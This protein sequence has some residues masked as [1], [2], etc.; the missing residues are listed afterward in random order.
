[1]R[2]Y[3]LLTAAWQVVA[4]APEGAGGGGGGAEGA[5]AAAGAAAAAAAGAAAGAGDGGGSLLS[6][7]AAAAAGDAGKA[8]AGDGKPAGEEGKPGEEA[9]PGEEKTEEYQIQP[10]ALDL[11][12][13]FADFADDVAAFNTAANE[14]L[15][16][17]TD[18]VQ[19][20]AASEA[21]AWAA[22]DYQAAAAAAGSKAVQDDLVAQDGRYRAAAQ[23]D[24]EI[25]GANFD[26]AVAD[27]LEAVRVFGTPEL[28]QFLHQSNAG[29]H[30]EVIR[31][32]AKAGKMAK[33]SPL[34]T[35]DGA[36]QGQNVSFANSLYGG[37]KEK[38]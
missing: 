16:K 28:L 24:P 4:F 6:D 34:Y 22:R 27:A 17:I 8:G 11:G 26:G 13:D 23:A 9:K 19:H 20:K 32:L 38:K 2:K 3:L 31:I 12:E 36:G 37:S 25:G 5:G 15:G 21:L 29:S 10:F 33:E 35:G 1:M 18:P 7:A 14:Y 30:P